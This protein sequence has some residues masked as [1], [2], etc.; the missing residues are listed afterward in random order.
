M[1]VICIYHSRDLDGWASG[2]VVKKWC[3]ENN[4]EIELIGYDYGQD[5][6]VEKIW[7]A[8]TNGILLCEDYC[9]ES[10]SDGF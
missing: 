1:K 5:V 4:Y 9:S 10:I 2:A 3:E 8:E 7:N 6:P